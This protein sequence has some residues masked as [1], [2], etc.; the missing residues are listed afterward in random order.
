MA[1]F[2]TEARRGQDEPGLTNVPERNQ[3]KGVSTGQLQT[4]LRNKIMIVRD[5]YAP[6]NK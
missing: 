5:Y 1:P 6:Q 2:R 4:N 3:P